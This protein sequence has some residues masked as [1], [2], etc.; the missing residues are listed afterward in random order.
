MSERERS[1]A[2]VVVLFVAVSFVAPMVSGRDF[3]PFLQYRMYAGQHSVETPFL[4]VQVHGVPADPARPE[5]FLKELDQIH[6]FRHTRLQGAFYWLLRRHPRDRERVRPAL[7]W[8]FD[9][10]EERRAAGL[11]EGP[12]LRALKLYV[13]EWMLEPWARNA[14]RPHK[15]LLAMVHPPEPG[16]GAPPSN[17]R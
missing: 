10:Y 12:Q 15:K 9:R 17:E 4:Q 1:F 6:P 5:F 13:V 16:A 3:W 11:H 8:L 2:T 14:S 7:A